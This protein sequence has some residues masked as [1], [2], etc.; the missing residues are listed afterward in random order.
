[1]HTHRHPIGVILFLVLALVGTGSLPVHAIYGDGQ[2]QSTTTVIAGTDRTVT[3]NVANQDTKTT[4]I[5]TSRDG[6]EG[7]A[8][9]PGNATSGADTTSS[10]QHPH[11]NTTTQSGSKSTTTQKD[12]VAPSTTGEPLPSSPVKDQ[13]TGTSS[14]ADAKGGSKTTGSSSSTPRHGGFGG[15]GIIVPSP[16]PPVMPEKD[17]PEFILTEKTNSKPDTTSTTS[18]YDEEIY[19]KTGTGYE[20]VDTVTRTISKPDRGEKEKEEY[21]VRWEWEVYYTHLEGKR[22]V[23]DGFAF[24][25]TRHGSSVTT[26]VA[27]PAPGKYFLEATPITNYGNRWGSQ[28]FW[29]Y[30]PSE[31]V[32]QSIRVPQHRIEMGTDTFLSGGGAVHAN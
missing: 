32:G 15:G 3:L 7:S 9:T 8:S 2:N 18:T 5:P 12:W 6:G 22:D 14:G 4:Y 24:G 21:V 25:F 10:V 27:F 30:V 1:M 26:T 16:P 11:S 23:V 20:K 19:I 29:V 31:L 17:A 28:S 13:K